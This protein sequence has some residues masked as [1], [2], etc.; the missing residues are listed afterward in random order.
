MELDENGY[1]QP[2]GQ[3]EQLDADTLVLATGQQ[4]DLSLLEGVA[5]IEEEDGVV[6][7]DQNLMTGHAGIFAGGDMVPAERTV[8]VAIGHG[9]RAAHGIDRW[10]LGEL[11]VAE[12]G[13]HDSASLTGV[14]PAPVRRRFRSSHSTP[15]TTRTRPRPS[16]L[17]STK[18]AAPP[19]STRSS[20]GSMSQTRCLRRGAACPAATAWHATTA[21]ASVPTTP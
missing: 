21:T 9:R 7:V 18:S 4:T 3:F 16:G 15:G 12:W 1:P 5:G 20:S 13:V 2:T 8:T 11:G 14:G 19:P 10:L 6:K 17:S